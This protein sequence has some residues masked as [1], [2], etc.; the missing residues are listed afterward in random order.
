MNLS[1]RIKQKTDQII[2]KFAKPKPQPQP[3][4]GTV[5]GFSQRLI[6]VSTSDG[7][8]L[9]QQQGTRAIGLGQQVVAHDNTAVFTGEAGVLP[10]PGRVFIAAP[11]KKKFEDYYLFRYRE[12]SPTD[13][14]LAEARRQTLVGDDIPIQS[15]SD[16]R[17]LEYHPNPAPF[18]PIPVKDKLLLTDGK[19]LAVEV[20]GWETSVP[21]LASYI[22]PD[23]RVIV[24]QGKITVLYTYFA[25]GMQLAKI[26]TFDKSL[27]LVDQKTVTLSTT[28]PGVS[29]VSAP[30]TISSIVSEFD[31]KV[32][33]KGLDWF[34]PV[35][36]AGGLVLNQIYGSAPDIRVFPI[37]VSRFDHYTLDKP[38]GPLGRQ[39]PPEVSGDIID[40]ERLREKAFAPAN[41]LT[42]ER[43]SVRPAD[44][45]MALATLVATGFNYR[46]IDVGEN[47]GEVARLATLVDAPDY[48]SDPE[49]GPYFDNAGIW[50]TLKRPEIP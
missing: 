3:T 13:R 47:D 10:K 39:R 44:A 27:R 1:E 15:L 7:Q 38:F 11:A 20:P 46:G 19:G 43:N 18:P 23:P 25:T 42:I 6:Q 45:S 35:F 9:R 26:T 50:N 22:A 16:G 12:Y 48:S 28:T 2:A 34:P 5:T 24:Y 21:R 17:I 4:H 29:G 36:M 14:A 31:H 41:F 33:A 37:S 40:Y 32:Y 49:L 30:S 8:Q